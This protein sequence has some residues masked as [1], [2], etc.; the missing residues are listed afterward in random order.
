LALHTILS[1][2]AISML[3]RIA[4]LALLLATKSTAVARSTSSGQWLGNSPGRTSTPGTIYAPTPP[5]E[6]DSG[7][8]EDSTEPPE[9]QSDANA[10]SNVDS[11][12]GGS[13][14]EPDS[15]LGDIPSQAELP[16]GKPSRL[17]ESSDS[18]LPALVFSAEPDCVVRQD[19]VTTISLALLAVSVAQVLW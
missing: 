17:S 16:D 9:P 4:V 1:T 10:P 11:L 19:C 14:Q 13:E 12:A 18:P 3:M 15:D 2:Q 5:S 7:S 6:D 8:Y